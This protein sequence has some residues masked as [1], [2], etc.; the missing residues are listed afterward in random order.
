MR[1]VLLAALLIAAPVSAQQT[2]W[3]CRDAKGAIVFQNLPCAVGMREL[4][5]KVYDTPDTRRA[6][7]YAE[8]VRREMDARN[9]ALHRPVVTYRSPNPPSAREQKKARCKRAQEAAQDAAMRGV[10]SWIREGL[11]RESIDAC[12]GL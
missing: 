12:F 3:K 8:R 4:G 11:E 6:A 9:R 5:A 2:I 1:L 10:S 7:V